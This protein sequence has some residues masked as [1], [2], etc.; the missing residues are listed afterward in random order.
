[1]NLS[2]RGFLGSII[3]AAVAPAIIRTPG[4]IMPI[5]PGLVMAR[6]ALEV[7]PLVAGIIPAGS[8]ML[9]EYAAPVWVLKQWGDNINIADLQ[10][11]TD[12]RV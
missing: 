10:E 6:H 12:E 4:L 2:R 9:I 3:A 8:T 11:L 7:T 5:K 1:M